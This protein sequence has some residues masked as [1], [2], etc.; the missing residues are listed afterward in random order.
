VRGLKPRAQSSK[1][2]I[3]SVPAPFRSSSRRIQVHPVN[4]KSSVNVFPRALR[5]LILLLSTDVK[6]FFRT[7]KEVFCT[8]GKK[9]SWHC[10][11]PA[12]GPAG[13]RRFPSRTGVPQSLIKIPRSISPARLIP[14]TPRKTTSQLLPPA[15]LR[16]D[17]PSCQ[18]LMR[19]FRTWR[20]SFGTIPTL[21]YHTGRWQRDHE[22]S[23][24]FRN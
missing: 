2:T 13:K 12:L 1:R 14:A 18:L 16:A 24:V 17:D 4:L 23:C 9:L 10:L 7:I 20:I 22:C 3:C 5:A 8:P 21:R 6:K 19:W 11:R 15:K